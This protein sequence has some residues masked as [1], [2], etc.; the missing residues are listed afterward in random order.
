MR[1]DFRHMLVGLAAIAGVGVEFVGRHVALPK[2]RLQNARE[3]VRFSDG[4]RFAGDGS[5]S[6]RSPN[7]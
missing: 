1:P 2:G 6:A 3:G 7:V 5:Q 4:C